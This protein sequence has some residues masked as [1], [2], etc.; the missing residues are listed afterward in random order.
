MLILTIYKFCITLKYLCSFLMFIIHILKM[1]HCVIDVSLM[2]DF[3]IKMRKMAYK[4]IVSVFQKLFTHMSVLFASHCCISSCLYKKKK[5]LVILLFDSVIPDSFSFSPSFVNLSLNF[6]WMP[7]TFV[8]M[9][10]VLIPAHFIS[11]HILFNSLCFFRPLLS[12]NFDE[13]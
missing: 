4:I 7:P 8:S 2:Q 5:R 9:A 13:I 6:I 1:W 10:S 11:F 12:S 3:W